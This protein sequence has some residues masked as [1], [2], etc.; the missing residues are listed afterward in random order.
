MINWQHL[1]NVPVECHPKT[2]AVESTR[3]K[4]VV[5]LQLEA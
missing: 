5:F 2:S 1:E 4:E 3:K